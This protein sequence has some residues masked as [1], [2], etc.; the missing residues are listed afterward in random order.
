MYAKNI[1]SMKSKSKFLLLNLLKIKPSS[2]VL[3]LLFGDVC[4][5][6]LFFFEIVIKKKNYKVPGIK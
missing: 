4:N 5:Y 3:T 6:F 1:Y 2:D